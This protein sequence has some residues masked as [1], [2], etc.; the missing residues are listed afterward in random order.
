MRLLAFTVATSAFNR[1]CPRPQPRLGCGSTIQCAGPRSTRMTARTAW[2]CGGGRRFRSR[3][4]RGK[5]RQ[6]LFKAGRVAARAARNGTRTD[7]RFEF[8][9][10]LVA[11]VFVDWHVGLLVCLVL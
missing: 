5:D 10:A 8:L 6:L 3:S 9:P 11:R 4:S 1:N 2:T 7:E